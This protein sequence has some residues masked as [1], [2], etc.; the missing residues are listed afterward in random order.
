MDTLTKFA[1]ALGLV[2][3]LSL[4]IV[5]QGSV[6]DAVLS[7]AGDVTAIPAAAVV[8]VRTASIPEVLGI[9]PGA[10]AYAVLQRFDTMFSVVG[11]GGQATNPAFSVFIPWQEA[12]AVG[13]A[14]A[15][16][17]E[18]GYSPE[19][20]SETASYSDT[21]SNDYAPTSAPTYESNTSGYNDS[22]PYSGNQGSG[23]DSSYGDQ[24]WFPGFSGAENPYGNITDWLGGSSPSTQSG[25]D[26]ATN[27]F[28]FQFGQT[29]GAQGAFSDSSFSASLN[30]FSSSLDSSSGAFS[31]TASPGSTVSFLESAQ[32]SFNS[33]FTPGSDNAFATP[34]SDEKGWLQKT[35][36]SFG[37][38]FGGTAIG[39]DSLPAKEG[40]QQVAATENDMG[41]PSNRQQNTETKDEPVPSEKDSLI[42]AYE[43]AK[44]NCAGDQACVDKYEKCTLGPVFQSMLNLYGTVPIEIPGE[45]ES[46]AAGQAKLQQME[47][48]CKPT[49]SRVQPSPFAAGGSVGALMAS[50][51]AA[52]VT[53][54][55]VFIPKRLL[56]LV[57][58]LVRGVLPIEPA[59]VM[60]A[61]T[62][63][64]TGFDT[65]SASS[66]FGGNNLTSSVGGG[67]DGGI[68][69]NFGGSAS[70]QSFAAGSFD[71]LS[72]GL[73]LSQE[74]GVFGDTGMSGGGAQS[75]L[76]DSA[77]G[78]SGFTANPAAFLGGSS[79]G[80][81]FS[82]PQDISS[83]FS[84]FSLS[85]PS[86]TTDAVATSTSVGISSGTAIDNGSWTTEAW[87]AVTSRADATMSLVSD[88]YYNLLNDSTASGTNGGTNV[89]FGNSGS[90]NATTHGTTASSASGG[91]SI[92]DTAT[93][94][95]FIPGSTASNS[96]A[97]IQAGYT[98]TDAQSTRADCIALATQAAQNEQNEVDYLYVEKSGSGICMRRSG[99]EVSP[100]DAQA[101]SSALTGADSVSRIHTHPLNATFGMNVPPPA[102]DVVFENGF[103]D[104]TSHQKLQML[105]VDSTGS[106]WQY[107]TTPGFNK[108]TD[109]VTTF[110]QNPQIQE[111]LQ[112]QGIDVN[113]DSTA[114]ITAS[115]STAALGAFGRDLQSEAQTIS[116]LPIGQIA[117]YQ[118]SFNKQGSLTT[119][120]I[121]E[122]IRKYKAVGVTITKIQ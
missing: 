52:D 119:A 59:L 101:M 9:V 21:S 122:A 77:S 23:A 13:G 37:N 91:Q 27:G 32:D 88:T 76:S 20:T 41:K 89:N 47:S 22:A 44:R 97:F 99:G 80:S 73:P 43:D 1:Q 3:I 92:V 117:Q 53:V 118:N 83:W 121:D 70:N 75:W 120:D 96:S 87:N 115:L 50:V 57:S 56:Q 74:S 34:A 55:Q 42:Q 78:F 46:R 85:A 31:D 10:F 104:E 19:S 114:A 24:S 35:E 112:S 39:D 26:A 94:T 8:S 106:V 61:F 18:D 38:F 29:E 86:T 64:S 48:E 69:T 54:L 109:R 28:G 107:E 62:G 82:E 63:G 84:G 58:S 30:E 60:D 49:S 15:E 25:L 95:A 93:A 103:I 67:F 116:K 33:F 5:G 90:A 36:D 66:G 81:G 72:L 111:F 98:P 102:L 100:A 12:A 65:S 4:I 17:D 16:L 6:S 79:Q 105:A 2:L 51:S 11:I 14:I 110:V 40:M 113:T 71:A 68:Y 108:Q 45:S 7:R